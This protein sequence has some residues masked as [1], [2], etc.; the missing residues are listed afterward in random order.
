MPDFA[1]K[2]FLSY[3]LPDFNLIHLSIKQFPGP[4]SR[5]D[6]SKL[7]FIEVT[8]AIPP[9]FNIVTGVCILFCTT[10]NL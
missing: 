4:I 9:I 1:I 2:P 6:I 5:L 10:N 8:Y 7:L 3:F